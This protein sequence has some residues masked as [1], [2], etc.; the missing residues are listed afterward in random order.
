VEW[1]IECK[2]YEIRDITPPNNIRKAMELQAESE[3]RKRAEILTSEG[4]RQ[5]DI[6]IAEGERQAAILK[7]EGEAKAIITRSTATS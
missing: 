5:A 6:N 1:G 2:R 4:R 3:R 7:A